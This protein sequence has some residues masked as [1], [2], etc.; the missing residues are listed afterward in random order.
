MCDRCRCIV[1]QAGVA[2]RSPGVRGAL[3]KRRLTVCADPSVVLCQPAM[4][5]VSNTQTGG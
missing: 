5:E 1:V 3:R 2:R 4:C